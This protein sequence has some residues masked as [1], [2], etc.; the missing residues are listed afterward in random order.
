MPRGAQLGEQTVGLGERSCRAQCVAASS[1]QLGSHLGDEGQ[2]RAHAG[3]PDQG[4][5]SQ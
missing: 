1:G 2:L 4:L 5:G 3:L